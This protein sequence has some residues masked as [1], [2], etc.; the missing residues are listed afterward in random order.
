[1][2]VEENKAVV[3]AWLAARNAHDIEAGVALWAEEKQ[4]WLR[5]AFERFTLGFPDLHVTVKDMIGEG[6]KVAVWWILQGTHL[7]IFREIPATGKTVNWE[8]CDLYVITDGK[9]ASLVRRADYL[10]LHQQLGVAE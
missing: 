10:S 4:T 6:D 1:M 2:S 7:G 3:H 5:A 8:V 9:I